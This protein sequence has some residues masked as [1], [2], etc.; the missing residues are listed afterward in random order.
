MTGIS[1][2]PSSLQTK[3]KK[4]KKKKKPK[5]VLPSRLVSHSNEK[6]S[7]EHC[8][9]PLFFNF[10]LLFFKRIFYPQTG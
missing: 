1:N 10:F 2:S 5:N 8:R 9:E 3:K 7:I 6:S 4:K